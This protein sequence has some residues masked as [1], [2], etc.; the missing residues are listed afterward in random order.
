M[1]DKVISF[2]SSAAGHPGGDQVEVVQTHGALVFLA[3]EV[4]LKSKRAVHYDYMD[5]RTLTQREAMLRRELE[6]NQPVAPQIYRDV[7]PVTAQPGGKL[8]LNGTGRPVE[9]VLRMKRFPAAHELSVIAK[10]NGISDALA[11]DL[12]REVHAFHAQTPMRACDGAKLIADILDELARVFA[13]M[14]AELG[15]DRIARFE[16]YSRA[17][18]ETIAPLL[19]QRGKAGHVRRG[20]GDLHLRNLVLIDG[21]PVPFD[22]LEFDEILGTCDVLY[23]LAFLLMDLRHHGLDRAA[24]ITLNAYL[25]AAAGDEDSGLAALPLFLSV[26]AAIRAMVTVQTAA[27]TGAPADGEAVGFLDD[28]VSFLRPAAPVLVLLGG[29]SGA[30]KTTVSRALAP[31]IG[32]CPGAVHLRSDLERKSMR[33]TAPEQRLDG[34]AYAP[35]ARHA[36]YDRL[37]S[38]AGRILA[39]GHSV[40]IDATFLDEPMRAAAKKLELKSGVAS[41]S[42]WLDAPLPTLIE[43]V[44][45]RIGDASDADGAIVRQQYAHADIPFG[46]VAVC[47][48]GTIEATVNLAMQAIDLRSE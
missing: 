20:H 7:V 3:G 42:L 48:T 24:N 23:D 31:L 43:R 34:E 1:Q 5:L 28:A 26:R 12:G 40:L 18:L 21:R 15:P 32:T 38:R 41:R 22:A 11:D 6:L 36:V 13:D 19:R 29:L 47:A 14:R 33:D 46:W 8:E 25:L 30:G 17:T 27:A 10:S 9:W 35:D 44:Q 16:R 37:F 39:A 4:A 2:L 45:A